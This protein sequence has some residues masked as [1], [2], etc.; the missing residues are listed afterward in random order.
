[1]DHF[2]QSHVLNNLPPPL[3]DDLLL[4]FWR[5][6]GEK[7]DHVKLLIAGHLCFRN[8]MC[9][10]GNSGENI[11]LINEIWYI[12]VAH[13]ISFYSLSTQTVFYRSFEKESKEVGPCGEIEK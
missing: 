2:Q 3:H 7:Y 6:G 5:I 10:C 1:M 9:V 11:C 4:I 8:K 13:Y 12:Y